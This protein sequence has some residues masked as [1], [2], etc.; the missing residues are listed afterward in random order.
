MVCE[1]VGLGEVI[2]KFQDVEFCTT[3]ISHDDP[4]IVDI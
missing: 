3:C 4:N 1:V 2:G